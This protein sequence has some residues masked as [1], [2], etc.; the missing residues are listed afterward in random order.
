[1]EIVKESFE[2]PKPGDEEYENPDDNQDANCCVVVTY[3]FVANGERLIVYQEN[4][5]PDEATFNRREVKGKRKWKEQ[6]FEK[7]PYGEPLF[8][9]ALRYL[10]HKEGI[11]SIKVLTNRGY[12]KVGLPREH[13]WEF[14]KRKPVTAS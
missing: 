9:E 10:I 11:P 13:W 3:Q 7:V 8:E 5:S 1:M 14:W 2:P 12:K 6:R 4:Y